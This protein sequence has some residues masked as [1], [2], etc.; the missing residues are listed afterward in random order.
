M[1]LLCLIIY[2][3]FIHNWFTE[4]TIL[5]GH[6]LA[7]FVS[8]SVLNTLHFIKYAKYS[9]LL[10]LQTSVNFILLIYEALLAS[11]SCYYN[12]Y[13][14]VYIFPE[15]NFNKNLFNDAMSPFNNDICRELPREKN[16]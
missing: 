15:K 5:L 8:F 2:R 13:T 14:T 12:D 4:E 10:L 11:Y 7:P 16:K 9:R 6:I 1:A 3:F